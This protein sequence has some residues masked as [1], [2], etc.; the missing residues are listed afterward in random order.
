MFINSAGDAGTDSLKT[1][2]PRTHSGVITVLLWLQPHTER[3]RTASD[4]GSTWVVRW[5]A[6]CHT[7]GTWSWT[8][9]VKLLFEW[10]G[11]VVTRIKWMC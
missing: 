10:I 7:G 1:Q 8:V 4:C 5:P 3:C 11:H 2:L 9:S 6:V